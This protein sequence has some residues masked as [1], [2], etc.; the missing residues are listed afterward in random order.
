MRE[1]I[2]TCL[3]QRRN[4]LR[5]NCRN[6]C[7]AELI[8]NNLNE[9]ERQLAMRSIDRANKNGVGADDHLIA[10]LD[11]YGFAISDGQFYTRCNK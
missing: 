9:V 5:R 3:K 11:S 7:G 2:S 4:K 8:V 6:H 10:R 1:R